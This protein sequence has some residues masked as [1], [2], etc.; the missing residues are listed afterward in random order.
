[1]LTTKKD[2]VHLVR[3][4]SKSFKAEAIRMAAHEV[5]L[6]RCEKSLEIEGHEI[7]YLRH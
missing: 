5:L 3:N 6:L 7:E 1:M 2:Y 4:E